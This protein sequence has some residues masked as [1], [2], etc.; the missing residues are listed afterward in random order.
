MT[1]AEDIAADAVDVEPTNAELT[2][3]ALD[4]LA[5]LLVDAALSEDDEDKRTNKKSPA[6]R[7]TTR[8]RARSRL[9]DEAITQQRTTATDL[10]DDVRRKLLATTDPDKQIELLCLGVD[11]LLCRQADLARLTQTWKGRR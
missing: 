9:Q 2:D 5:G 11:L 4:L 8:D 10:L 6:M 7:R 3:A 1:A